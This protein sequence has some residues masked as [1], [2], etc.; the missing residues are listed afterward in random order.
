MTRTQVNPDAEGTT[1]EHIGQVLRTNREAMGLSQTQLAAGVGAHLNTAHRV[2]A[3]R[4][5]ILLTYIETML[6][7]VGLEIALVPLGTRTP[8]EDVLDSDEPRPS[9]EGRIA[10]AMAILK[11]AIARS[12]DDP[13]SRNGSS[14]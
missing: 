4:G 7:T 6:A 11:E 9:H 10:R 1:A 2:E 12:K 5:T 13:R 8:V 3:G 14:H